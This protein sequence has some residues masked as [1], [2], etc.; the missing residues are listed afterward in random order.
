MPVPFAGMEH[1]RHRGALWAPTNLAWRPPARRGALWAPTA[2]PFLEVK[3]SCTRP[4]AQRPSARASSAR[5]YTRI[6]RPQCPS[7]LLFRATAPDRPLRIEPAT[8]LPPR[9]LQ[10]SFAAWEGCSPTGVPDGEH[11]TH[12]VAAGHLPTFPFTPLRGAHGIPVDAAFS[13]P[14]DSQCYRLSLDRTTRDP[15]GGPTLLGRTED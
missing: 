4:P 5:T 9:E 15:S 14:T 2:P 10:R 6:A 1:Q 8:I 13:T 7:V 3:V 11:V 12:Y